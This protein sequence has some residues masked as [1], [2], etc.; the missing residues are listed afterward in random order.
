MGE[1]G[2]VLVVEPSGC[3]SHRPRSPQHL[4]AIVI[5]QI[6]SNWGYVAKFTV[7][8]LKKALS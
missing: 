7:Y 1:R 8:Q 3:R 6:S 2:K 4:V 5:Q